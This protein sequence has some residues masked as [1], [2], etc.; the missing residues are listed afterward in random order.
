[1]GSREKIGDLS[2]HS[3]LMFLNTVEHLTRLQL[4]LCWGITSI[5]TV[6]LSHLVAGYS[7]AKTSLLE[8]LEVRTQIGPQG[9]QTIAIPRPNSKERK[10]GARGRRRGGKHLSV[11]STCYSICLSISLRGLLT[12]PC[13]FNSRSL[14]VYC[15]SLLL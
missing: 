14:S 10:Y 7:E 2:L 6:K 8:L 15:R 12:T 1:M 13:C 5:P 3:L 9:S 11:N 4:M